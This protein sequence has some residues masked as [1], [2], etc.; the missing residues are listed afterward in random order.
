VSCLCASSFSAVGSQRATAR[1][2]SGSETANLC[3]VVSAT[4]YTATRPS[5]KSARTRMVVATQFRE[6][7]AL[8]RF[9]L[10]CPFRL[11]PIA[12]RLD[13]AIGDRVRDIIN[14]LT[15]LSRIDRKHHSYQHYNGSHSDPDAL[16]DR[17]E[18]MPR[19]FLHPLS[20]LLNPGHPYPWA[21]IHRRARSRSCEHVRR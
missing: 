16:S 7:T 5:P 2:R 17:Y 20:G 8:S 18:Q 21:G 19:L 1:A 15:G 4:M 12:A 11:L 3:P 14:A 6:P 10:A 9:R 13:L